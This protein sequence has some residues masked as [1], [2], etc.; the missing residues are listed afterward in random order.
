MYRKKL[1]LLS[2]TVL[3]FCCSCPLLLASDGLDSNGNTEY[4]GVD[5]TTTLISQTTQDLMEAMDLL[6][7]LHKRS[8][9]LSG[10]TDI[11]S[12]I[13]TPLP[14]NLDAIRNSLIKQQLLDVLSATPFSDPTK[15]LTDCHSA[16]NAL[17]KYIQ[18]LEDIAAKA[19]AKPSQA[20]KNNLER[21]D[22]ESAQAEAL[23]GIHTPAELAPTEVA[24]EAPASTLPSPTTPIASPI[25]AAPLPLPIAITPA[26]T[27]VP[28]SAAIAPV[29]ELP[30]P[31][32]PAPK[33]SMPDLFKKTAEPVKTPIAAP[34]INMPTPPEPTLPIATPAMPALPAAPAEQATPPAGLT[35]L[36][37]V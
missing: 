15:H 11:E 7:M 5:N 1:L 16:I 14:R 22:A 26:P 19:P 28:A 8:A 33:V 2:A 27:V 21:S 18:T 24:P 25:A 32:T 23:Y 6:E 29:A 30:K 37:V 31:A 36:P 35:P 4:S 3:L 12:S 10:S 9:Q 17:E 34:Q 20:L 13:S